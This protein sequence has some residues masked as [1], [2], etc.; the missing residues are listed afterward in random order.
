MPHTGH[1]SW[2]S[3]VGASSPGFMSA[4][5]TPLSMPDQIA[6]MI[7]PR[8]GAAAEDVAL[9][10]ADEQRDADL[11]PVVG[12]QLEHVGLE[13]ALAGRLDDDLGAPAVG[14]E[15]DAVVVALREADLVEQRVGLVGIVRD[16]GLLVFGLKSGLS[17]ST[18]SALSLPRP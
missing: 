8:D 4:V 13:R 7:W 12:D 1:C 2:S 15:A 17:G 11:A 3:V 9:R 14:Q 10:G 18:V 6:I 5:G 16:P